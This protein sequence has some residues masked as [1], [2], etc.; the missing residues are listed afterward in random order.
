MPGRHLTVAGANQYT[1]RGEEIY[2]LD[3]ERGDGSRFIT[4]VLTIEQ[5]TPARIR[6]DGLSAIVS[7]WRRCGADPT[8]YQHPMDRWELQKRFPL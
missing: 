8:G 2:V 3:V 5:A 4:S 1:F 7:H 6:H